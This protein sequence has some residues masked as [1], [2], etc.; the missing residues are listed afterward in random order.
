MIPKVKSCQ[1]E[2]NKKMPV[3]LAPAVTHVHLGCMKYLKVKL[4]H[5]YENV[6]VDYSEPAS[7]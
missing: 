1:E 4:N 2:E 7:S 3:T 5:I 6:Y